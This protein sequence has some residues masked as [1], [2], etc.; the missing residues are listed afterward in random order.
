[1]I[2]AMGITTITTMRNITAT[3]DRIR[4]GRIQLGV[5]LA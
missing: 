1:M 5:A 3:M 4:P 2:M